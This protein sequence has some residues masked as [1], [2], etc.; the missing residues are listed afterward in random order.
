M[1]NRRYDSYKVTFHD[2]AVINELINLYF[3]LINYLILSIL[4]NILIISIFI[5][6]IF[7]LFI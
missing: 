1:L 5:D 3:L 2:I 7:N 6:I 4:L